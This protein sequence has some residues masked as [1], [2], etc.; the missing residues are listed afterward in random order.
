MYVK[1]LLCVISLVSVDFLLFLSKDVC[2]YVGWL[3][4]GSGC[5]ERI[6]CILL[7]LYY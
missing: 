1:W 4:M 5:Y 3:F 7:S 2:D 6:D